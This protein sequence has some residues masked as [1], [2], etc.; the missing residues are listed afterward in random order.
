ELS[1]DW[2]LLHAPVLAQEV[3][4]FRQAHGQGASYSAARI[5]RLDTAGASLLL[6]LIGGSG[7]LGRLA[8]L[9]S[10]SARLLATVAQ[11]DAPPTGLPPR[12]GLAGFVADIGASVRS[13]WRDAVR[14]IGFL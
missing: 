6:E 1:G 7:H 11:A 4:A 3:A 14:L 13:I 10:H 2:T 5:G 8:E 12:G 9:P